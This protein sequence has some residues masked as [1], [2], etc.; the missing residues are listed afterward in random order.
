MHV[1]P[2]LVRNERLQYEY[3]TGKEISEEYPD[4]LLLSATY[5]YCN[6]GKPLWYHHG[7]DIEVFLCINKVVRDTNIKDFRHLMNGNITHVLSVTYFCWYEGKPLCH[8]WII[9]ALLPHTTRRSCTTKNGEDL[10]Y[11][12]ILPTGK[13][14]AEEQPDKLLLS[15]TY[16]YCYEGKPLCHYCGISVGV[17]LFYNTTCWP[18]L[19]TP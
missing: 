12:M 4:Q 14:T 17:L 1:P 2:K 10:R 19:Q 8:Y 7:S 9:P 6:Q 13:E 15:V 5:F 3:P 18:K 16:F 11:P